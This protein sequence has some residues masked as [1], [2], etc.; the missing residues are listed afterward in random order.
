MT[1]AITSAARTT[2]PVSWTT[3]AGHTATVQMPTQ[4]HAAYAS[5]THTATVVQ[6]ADTPTTV[7]PAVATQA[8]VGGTI[9]LGGATL[10]GLGILVWFVA[11]WKGHQKEAK[12]AFVMGAIAT[13]LVGSWGLFGT[14][15]N[16]VKST[17]D[18]VGNSV[19][20]TISQQSSV[21]R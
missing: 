17:G 9:G 1:L 5:D 3:Q 19:G 8:S 11:R 10:I 2:V 13:V 15:T 4:L 18:S 14:V 21:T 20:N 6:L 16:T 7:A 12:R